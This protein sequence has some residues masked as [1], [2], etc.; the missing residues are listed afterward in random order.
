M[1]KRVC[2]LVCIMVSLL[3]NPMSVYAVANVVDG[4]MFT[5]DASAGEVVRVA[6]KV[7]E[8]MAP[9]EMTMIS[10]EVGEASGEGGFEQLNNHQGLS[11]EIV[12]DMTGQYYREVE[13]FLIPEGSTLTLNRNIY[14]DIFYDACYH[15]VIEEYGVLDAAEYADGVFLHDN[16]FVISGDGFVEQV[17]ATINGRTERLYIGS[18]AIPN[19]CYRVLADGEKVD[20]HLRAFES[21]EIVE[22]PDLY[23]LTDGFSTTASA[24]EV[25]KVIF[26]V[27]GKDNTVREMEGFLLPAGAQIVLDETLYRDGMY[28]LGFHKADSDVIARSWQLDFFLND[29]GMAEVEDTVFDIRIP[30]SSGETEIFLCTTNTMDSKYYEAVVEEE[31][32]EET[33][34]SIETS[35]DSSDANSDTNVSEEENIADEADAQDTLVDE[36]EAALEVSGLAVV[37][38][39][40]GE[41]KP[42]VLAVTS[43]LFISLLTQ[44]PLSFAPSVEIAAGL[45]KK[46]GELHINGDVDV[47]DI[48]YENVKKIAIPVHVTDE[49]NVAWIFT[50]KV[51]TPGHKKL[52]KTIAVPLS[53]SSAEITLNLAEDYDKRINE[54]ITVFLEVVA[55]GF[56]VH[57]ERNL[58]EKMVEINIIRK[59]EVKK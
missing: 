15:A 36:G 19:S 20:S 22:D 52:I 33:V 58:L 57:G 31:V 16:N 49:L 28:E 30:L 26:H 32:V 48:H 21:G 25:Q 35:V 14:D 7:L 6:F 37:N 50:A 17:D 27:A 4:E 41:N 47:P 53:K 23:S 45:T 24:D 1:K 40:V 3:M 18:T 43:C 13:G 10:S 9:F 12:Y 29:A 46:H 39:F 54:D 44:V 59:D 38:K 5:T 8:T 2:L 34:A 56:D 11:F 42:L 55:L 51:F